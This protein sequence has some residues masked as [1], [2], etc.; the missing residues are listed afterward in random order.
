MK[1]SEIAKRYNVSKRTLRY[2][3][4]IG[5]LKSCRESDRE[6]RWYEKSQVERL[7]QILLLKKASLKLKDI[8]KV[9]LDEDVKALKVILQQRLDEVEEELK[10]LQMK[11]SLIQDMIYLANDISK[12]PIHFYQ[13]INEQVYLKNYI[14]QIE[15]MKYYMEDII[16]LEFGEG[17]VEVAIKE[18]LPRQVGQLKEKIINETAKALPLIRMRDNV[19]LLSRQYSIRIKGVV[20]K[21]KE[22]ESHEKIVAI[23]L[24]D[25]EE[26]VVQNL[27]MFT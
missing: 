19:E 21:T 24:K 3:E 18:E 22:I 17:L 15:G 14:Q 20:V 7:E 5:L 26:A 4:E 23:M 13:L 2:Y 16:L 27:Q 9:L 10:E 8:K 6:E 11:K 1:I 12:P 25:L